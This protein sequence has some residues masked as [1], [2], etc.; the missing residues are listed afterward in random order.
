MSDN[1]DNK[2]EAPEGDAEPTATATAEGE[3]A[4]A[5][6]TVGNPEYAHDDDNPADDADAAE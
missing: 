6:A 3:G 2:P 1:R 4:E 5:T